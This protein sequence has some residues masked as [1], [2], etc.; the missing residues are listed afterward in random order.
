MGNRHLQLFIA[1]QLVQTNWEDN[2]SVAELLALCGA[3]EIKIT[4]H[5]Y[6]GIELVGSLGH[7]ITAQDRHLHACSGDI[8]LYQSNH[9]VIMFGENSWSYTRLGHISE[10]SMKKLNKTLLQQPQ[11][12]GIVAKPSRSFE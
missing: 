3:G 1:G 10:T 8:L 6:G 9:I 12:V 11:T 7:S 2:D 5:P 4:A